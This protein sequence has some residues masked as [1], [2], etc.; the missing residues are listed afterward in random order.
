LKYNHI[1]SISLLE[2][3]AHRGVRRSARDDRLVVDAPRGVLTAE[4]RAELGRHK[5]EILAALRAAARWRC[6]G[7]FCR[8]QAGRWMSAWG[9]VNCKNC[10]PPSFALSVVAEFEAPGRTAAARI[11]APVRAETEA[12]AEAEGLTTPVRLDAGKPL[13]GSR[14]A[15]YAIQGRPKE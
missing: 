7:R 11:E 4:D 2:S 8:H 9:V 14:E 5:R 13:E 15:R 1:Q 6:K 10:V 12:A 3:L